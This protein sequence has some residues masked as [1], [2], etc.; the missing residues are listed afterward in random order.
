MGMGI[1]VPS[2]K[3]G[4]NALKSAGIGFIAGALNAGS[5]RIFGSGLVGSAVAVGLAGAFLDETDARIIAVTEG[6]DIGKNTVGGWLGGQSS[7]SVSSQI[8][9]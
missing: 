7:S 8:V 6:R 3:R 9:L 1:G 4:T 2:V 5:N